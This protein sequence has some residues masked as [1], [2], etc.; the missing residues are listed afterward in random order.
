MDLGAMYPL[1]LNNR[2]DVAGHCPGPFP[3][4]SPIVWDGPACA[5]RR[6]VVE[7]WSCQGDEPDEYCGQVATGINER[8]DIVGQRFTNFATSPGPQGQSWA[9]IFPSQGGTILLDT[10][11]SASGINN[12]G[13]IV[14]HQFAGAARTAVAWTQYGLE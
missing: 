5:I 4:G 10:G 3:G 13:T 9:V 6:G 7:E 8:G 2:G 11:T 12:R 1:A 14:G